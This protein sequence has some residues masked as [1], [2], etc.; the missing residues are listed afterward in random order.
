MLVTSNL[1]LNANKM[2]LILR[3]VCCNAA[4]AAYGNFLTVWYLIFISIWNFSIYYTLFFFWLFVLFCCILVAFF[5]LKVSEAPD[6]LFTHCLLRWAA[7]D[8][9]CVVQTECPKECGV[10]LSPCLSWLASLLLTPLKVCLSS[11]QSALVTWWNWSQALG[12]ST[13]TCQW[14]GKKEP[15]RSLLLLVKHEVR[16]EHL[17]RE[18][19]ALLSTVKDKKW[20]ARGRIINRAEQGRS[21]SMLKVW[22]GW[23]RNSRINQ[24]QNTG[25]AKCD[26]RSLGTLLKKHPEM[27]TVISVAF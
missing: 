3:T 10:C 27:V 20:G 9:I 19:V 15:A 17:D 7:R 23:G 22:G 18:R 12:H 8:N 2:L 11:L 1:F 5:N 6:F 26:W 13:E 14:L 21:E 4:Y 24:K 25:A 16:W